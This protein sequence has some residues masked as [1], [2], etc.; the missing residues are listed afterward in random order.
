M[1]KK[2]TH[3]EFVKEIFNYNPNVDVL[4][5]YIDVHTSVKFRCKICGYE[6]ESTP[7]SMK[8]SHAVCLQ[9]I[10]K[11]ITPHSFRE[12]VFC[13]VGNEYSVMSDYIDCKTPIEFIHNECGTKF[14]MKP[15]SFFKS[16]TKCSN[17]ECKHKI[18]TRLNSEN[19]IR[20]VDSLGYIVK[21][22][23]L[24][25]DEMM[26]FECKKCHTNFKLNKASKIYEPVKISH[27]PNC[28]SSKIISSSADKFI[29]TFNSMFGNEF[30]I[31]GEYKGCDSPIKILHR[32]CGNVSEYY[33]ASRVLT[34]Y[35]YPC[36]CCNITKGEKSIMNYLDNNCIVYEHQKKYDNLFGVNSGYLSYDF[37]IEDKNLLIEFQGKQHYEAIE[38]F[39]GQEYFNIQQEHDRRKRQYAKDN[40]ITLLEIAYWDFEN[41]E[42]I[43]SREL[44]LVA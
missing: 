36:K 23:Y 8:R 1:P 39:G 26:I 34:D 35:L 40:N 38:D 22:E 7:H 14:K 29:Q 41:I 30:E 4:S 43:L 5:E 16:Q 6:W 37:Y 2:K 19:F 12:M 28:Y 21:S 10:G 13:E 9:C 32:K 31:S 3:E 44:G 18:H 42:E 33:R 15:R 25:I 17:K 27:C 24:G 11:I 20:R